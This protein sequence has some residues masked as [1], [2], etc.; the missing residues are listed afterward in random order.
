[1]QVSDVYVGANQTSEGK[2]HQEGPESFQICA[3][4]EVVLEQSEKCLK[5]VQF[6][7]G[8]KNHNTW[9]VGIGKLYN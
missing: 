6:R 1:M 8:R 7:I 9:F 2:W 4:A 3:A 5:D